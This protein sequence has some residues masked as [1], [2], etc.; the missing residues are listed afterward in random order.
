M[1]GRGSKSRGRRHDSDRGQ[2]GGFTS[3]PPPTPYHD[4]YP[5]NHPPHSYAP[6]PPPQYSSSFYESR[7]PPPP[8][9]PLHQR[10]RLERK[11]SRIADNYRSLAEVSQL[12]FISVSIVII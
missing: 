9:P 12:S 11:Y 2:H 5:Q 4:P 6:P 3:Y 10:K 8:P 7:A 1:G